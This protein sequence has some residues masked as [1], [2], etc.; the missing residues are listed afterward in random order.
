MVLSYDNEWSDNCYSKWDSII[1]SG[2]I[3]TFTTSNDAIIGTGTV[4]LSDAVDQ[5]LAV[6]MVLFLEQA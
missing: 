4:Q 5:Q 1:F 2:G 3:L 6:L